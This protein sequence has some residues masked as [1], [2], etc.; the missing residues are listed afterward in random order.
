MRSGIKAFL[1]AF[2]ITL[3][4]LMLLGVGTWSGIKVWEILKSDYQAENAYNELQESFNTAAEENSISIDW[5]NIRQLYPDIVGWLYCPDTRIDYPIVQGSDN[6][7]YLTH[8]ATGEENRHGAIFVDWRNTG[9]LE[10]SHILVYGHNMNDKTMLHE[11][12][13]W[14][15]EEY[16][17]AH[18]IIYILTAQQNYEIR[19]FNACLVDPSEDIYDLNCGGDKEAWLDRWARCSWF[20]AGFVPEAD[21]PVITFSTCGDSVRRFVVQGS[22]YEYSERIIK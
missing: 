5:Q 1:K 13:N 12:L 3:I 15:N 14:G 2:S 7:Y 4:M 8:L 18:S 6:E 17:A 9:F 20:T 11:L 19:L 16:A 10:D 22:V 21:R